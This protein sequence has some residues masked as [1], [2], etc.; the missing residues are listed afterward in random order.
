MLNA[1][2]NNDFAAMY[3]YEDIMINLDELMMN[4]K[5]NA[6]YEGKVKAAMKERQNT[7]AYKKQEAVESLS[8]EVAAL[9]I[10][11]KLT[12]SDIQRLVKKIIEKNPIDEEKNLKLKIVEYAIKM[13]RDKNELSTMKKSEKMPLIKIREQGLIK[14]QH[15][16]DILIK[17]GYI[18]RVVDEFY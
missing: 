9:G 8:I 14:K 12:I 10:F 6:Q 5:R 16:Y 3:K 17:D 7:I 1:I 15:I 13:N 4:H 18:K 11:D 2:R